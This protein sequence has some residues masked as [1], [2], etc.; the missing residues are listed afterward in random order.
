MKLKHK[1]EVLD[2]KTQKLISNYRN[3]LLIEFF[4]GIT[5]LGSPPLVMLMISVLWSVGETPTAQTL[6]LGFLISGT[7]VRIIKKTT[8]KTR[9]ENH[10]GTFYSEKSFPSGHSTS[11]FM[12]AT[13]LNHFYNKPLAF[14][15]L[16]ATVATSRIYLDDHYLTD[17]IA[18][19]VTGSIIGT[20]LIINII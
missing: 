3:P 20:S 9:P 8:N 10:T 12:T 2:N 13:V 19:A 15:T 14:F 16:A 4:Q 6:L 5:S 1:V 7:I 17:I 11:S 18:G